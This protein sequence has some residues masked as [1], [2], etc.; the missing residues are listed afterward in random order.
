MI[1]VISSV[2]GAYYY[3]RVI[4]I[5]YFDTYPGAERANMP[6]GHLS[7]LS[8]HALLVVVLFLFP[9]PLLELCLRAIG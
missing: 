8:V 2:I 4:K 9:Q 3:L 6:A 1:A 5:I 7:V